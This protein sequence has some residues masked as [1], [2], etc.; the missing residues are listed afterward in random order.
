MNLKTALYATITVCTL[1]L[2]VFCAT[3]YKDATDY[4]LINSSLI[5]HRDFPKPGINFYD[6]SGVLS[7]PKAFKA[8]IDNLTEHYKNKK[9]DAILAV[10]SRGFLFATPLAYKLNIPVVMLRKP[11]KLPGKT[12]N[13][14]L[15]KEYGKDALE[16]QENAL[17]SGQR[18]IIID[19]LIATGGTFKAAIKLARQAQ[20]E[21]IEVTAIVELTQFE[22]SRDL[23]VGMYSV[24]K[25]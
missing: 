5:E 25:K 23:N 3:L 2:G 1:G 21:V 20:A 8:V 12:I 17:Q 16:M 11:G 4:N 15:C 18:V 7:K 22:N 10:D 14:G 13:S 6:V 9:I 19:D 24:V